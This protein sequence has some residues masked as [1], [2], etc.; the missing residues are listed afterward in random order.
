MST[1]CIYMLEASSHTAV[2]EAVI[3]KHFAYKCNWSALPGLLVCFISAVCLCIE[4]TY[5]LTCTW[6]C[7]PV[8]CPTVCYV[9]LSLLCCLC[10]DHLSVLDLPC[11]VASW[12]CFCLLCL[13]SCWQMYFSSSTHDCVFLVKGIWVHKKNP[14]ILSHSFLHHLDKVWNYLNS[15]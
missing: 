10:L 15:G 1:L 5:F 13:S 6:T 9:N 4:T 14:N 7:L 8:Y 3:V 12:V 11:W 2:N